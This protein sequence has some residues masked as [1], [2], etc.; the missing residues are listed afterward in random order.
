MLNLLGEVLAIP[1]IGGGLPLSFLGTFYGTVAMVGLN[2][3]NGTM[4]NL[5]WQLDIHAGNHTQLAP[6]GIVPPTAFPAVFEQWRH[7]PLEAPALALPPNPA[8]FTLADFADA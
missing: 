2:D 7:I 3:P 5:G 4:A 6:Q 1:R 8:L